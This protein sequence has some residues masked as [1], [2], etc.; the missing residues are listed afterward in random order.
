MVCASG[1]STRQERAI[2]ANQAR[3]IG[4]AVG[5]LTD[6]TMIVDVLGTATGTTF[7]TIALDGTPGDHIALTPPGEG[8][9]ELVQV[10]L[11]GGIEAVTDAVGTTVLA[12]G[13]IQSGATKDGRQV[14]EGSTDNNNFCAASVLTPDSRLY[15][16]TDPLR[17][18]QLRQFS[19]KQ[20][21]KVALMKCGA[22]NNVT[23]L[24]VVLTVQCANTA[25][26]A[27]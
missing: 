27:R 7:A 4:C 13:E 26:A 2:A 21:L 5:E 17:V 3:G 16:N 23:C 14:W 10:F 18:G 20:P 11:E 6:I 9:F 22:A 1:M 8:T 25:P 19:Q 24:S 15:V 12:T